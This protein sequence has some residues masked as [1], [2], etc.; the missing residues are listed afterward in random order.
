MASCRIERVKF[1]PGP[2]LEPGPQALRATALST[3][4]SKIICDV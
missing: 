2:G 4:V 1:Y 3:E